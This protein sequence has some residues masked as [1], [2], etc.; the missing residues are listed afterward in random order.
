MITHPLIAYQLQDTNGGFALIP[1]PAARA[2]IPQTFNGYRCLPLLMANQ[3]GWLV[4][5]PAP[6]RVIWDGGAG[7][8]SVIVEEA[9][10]TVILV[11]LV[12]SDKVSSLGRCPTYSAL[13][14]D[15][16]Y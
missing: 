10:R 12:T 16:T 6:I 15:T 1:A 8:H 4:L 13:R 14:P 5:N 3:S 2:W 9:V 11:S 7:V